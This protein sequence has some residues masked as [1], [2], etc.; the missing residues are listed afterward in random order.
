MQLHSLIQTQAIGPQQRQLT[1]RRRPHLGG[2]VRSSE[3]CA[4]AR[5]WIFRSNRVRAFQIPKFSIGIL[6]QRGQS[7]LDLQNPYSQRQLCPPGLSF[8][9]NAQY[10][11]PQFARLHS[12]STLLQSAEVDFRVRQ[13]E[14]KQAKTVTLLTVTIGDSRKVAMLIVKVMNS[15]VS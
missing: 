14:R 15:T 5:C 6:E 10:R 3:G 9:E 13:T 2:L 4:S 1:S 12:S 7:S 11:A 8:F